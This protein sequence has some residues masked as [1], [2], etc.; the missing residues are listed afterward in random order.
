[1]NSTFDES[2]LDGLASSDD[3]YQLWAIMA[4][5]FVFL[6]ERVF[7]NG[8]FAMRCTKTSCFCGN[9]TPP[10]SP[11]ASVEIRRKEVAGLVNQLRN[12]LA[13]LERTVSDGDLMENLGV[14]NNAERSN[15]NSNRNSERTSERTSNRNSERMVE[16]TV[17]NKDASGISSPSSSYT[18]EEI[19]EFQKFNNWRKAKKLR[20]SGSKDISQDQE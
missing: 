8:K 13:V 16:R 3:K 20:K 19:E 12:N 2:L 10:V 18:K 11:D 14:K 4:L 6:L 1:M 15:H 17:Y 7:K 5:Q 9:R